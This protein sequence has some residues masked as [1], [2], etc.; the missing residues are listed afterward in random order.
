MNKIYVNKSCLSTLSLGD[1]VANSDKAIRARGASEC[2]RIMQFDTLA[3]ASCL[4]RLYF[5]RFHFSLRRCPPRERTNCEP[6]VLAAGV[7]G[8]TAA[9]A[10]RVAN[11]YGSDT[12]TGSSGDPIGVSTTSVFSVGGLLRYACFVL[13]L[14]VAGA[15]LSA[16]DQTATGAEIAKLINDLGADSFFVRTRAKETLQQL[17]LEAFDD[18]HDAQFHPDNE[19]AMAAR[20]LVSSLM[21][22]WSKDADPPEVRE[23]LSEYGAQDEV[24]RKSRID[25]LAELSE[26]KG[27]LALVRLARFETSLRLSRLAALAAM[28]Q[29]IDGEAVNRARTAEQ[30]LETL[31]DSER[32]SAEWLRIYAQDLNSGTY[33]VDSWRALIA[34]QRS[35]VD[36]AATDASNRDSVLELVRICA[37]RSARADLRDE[38][39][40]LA[41]ENIDLIAPTT[42]DLIDAVT[43]AIDQNLHP[44]VLHLQQAHQRMF[45]QHPI[46]LYG[47]AESQVDAGNQSEADSLADQASR[48]QPLPMTDEE[49]EKLQPKEIEEMAQAHRMIAGTLRQRGLFTWAER[50]Y[51]LVINSLDFGDAPAAAARDELSLMLGELLRHQDVVDL[52]EPLVDRLEKDAKLQQ[53]LNNMFFSVDRTKS[54]LLFHK[55]QSLID[56]GE[57]ETARP[58]LRKAFESY[59]VNIDILIAMY[60]LDGDEEWNKHVRSELDMATRQSEQAVQQSKLRAIQFGK[61]FEEKIAD[62]YNQ[63]AWLVANTEGNY[64]KALEYSL[65]SLEVRTED[66]STG[67][68]LDTCARCYFAVGDLEK[69]IVTQKRAIKLLPHSP[70]LQ[71]QLEEFQDAKAAESSL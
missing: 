52:L 50:E 4:Y 19:I 53:K 23:A 62:A 35:Q 54:T 56:Q 18:L 22:S 48:I 47:A 65:K 51:R 9:T 2:V 5:Q 27:L 49:R 44:F 3:R 66:E 7:E 46:L 10:R 61:I 55:A 6:T 38:A 58:I 15:P 8:T 30:I 25:M 28:R 34:K 71:R 14:L 67:A 63:Y 29:P 41:T 40:Q 45:S 36:T 16:S 24:E 60:R 39:V 32:R 37:S 26:R 17:G 20:F 59:R 70:P 21:V 33:S 57:T 13:F 64:E 42:R 11:G 43:W 68:R 69:A 1:V 12:T 31:G